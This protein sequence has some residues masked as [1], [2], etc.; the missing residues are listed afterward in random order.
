MWGVHSGLTTIS[1]G[2]SSRFWSRMN[3]NAASSPDCTVATTF[4]YRRG[5]LD[6]QHP[7]DGEPLKIG[8]SEARTGPGEQRQS[9]RFG[10]FGHEQL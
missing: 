7:A 9:P 10:L 2:T 5:Y 1:S 4:Q 8:S 6:T 3:P